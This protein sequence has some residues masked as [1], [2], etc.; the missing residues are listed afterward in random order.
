MKGEGCAGFV[1]SV[2]NGPPYVGMS[3]PEEGQVEESRKLAKCPSPTIRRAKENPSNGGSFLAHCRK[4]LH[5]VQLM[6]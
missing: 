2:H 4:P 6:C 5:R 3:L 1:S